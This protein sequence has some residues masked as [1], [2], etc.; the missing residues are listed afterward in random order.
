M[1]LKGINAYKK[2]SL[3]Q[4]IASADPHRLTLMLMQGSLDRIA[5]AKGCMERKDFAGKAEHLSRVNA[6]LLNLRDTLDLDVGGDVAQNLYSLY[7]Y[8]ITRLL[9]ANVQNSLQIL[10]E[11][12]SLLLPIK[13]AWAS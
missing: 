5:Y 2:D 3:K 10:D 4:D 8:M 7:D 6:I 1:T 11:V 9:D 12:I 13:K